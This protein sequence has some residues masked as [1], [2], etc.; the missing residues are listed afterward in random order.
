M[1]NGTNKSFWLLSSVIFIELA[2]AAGVV[3]GCFVK[4]CEEETRREVANI[5]NGLAAKSFALYAAESSIRR[6]SND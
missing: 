1:L 5:F 6:N 4:E 2:V 3:F